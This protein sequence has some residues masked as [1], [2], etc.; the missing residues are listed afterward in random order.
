MRAYARTILLL[1]VN[2]KQYLSFKHCIFW[3]I[4]L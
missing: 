3:T 4:Y 2:E 1:V